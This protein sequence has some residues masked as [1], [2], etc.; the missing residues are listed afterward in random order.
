MMLMVTTPIGTALSS[1]GEKTLS[2]L[3]SRRTPN[4][5]PPPFTFITHEGLT[6]N[7]LADT[8]D[9]RVRDLRWFVDDHCASILAEV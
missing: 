7:L 1:H 6:S 8:L 2:P 5:S 4:A 9:H 3:S